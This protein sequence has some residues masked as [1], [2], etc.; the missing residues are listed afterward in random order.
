LAAAFLA[1]AFLA[2]AGFSAFAFLGAAD[3][4]AAFFFTRAGLLLPFEPLNLF[5]LAVLLSPLPIIK[6]FFVGANVKNQL[7]FHTKQNPGPYWGPGFLF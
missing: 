3:F 6:M 7:A 5:P 2:A 4:A 1:G